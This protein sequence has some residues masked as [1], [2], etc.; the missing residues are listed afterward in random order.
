MMCLSGIGMSRQALTKSW[1]VNSAAKKKSRGPEAKTSDPRTYLP[2]S[3][4]LHTNRNASGMSFTIHSG[5]V[6]IGQK[7]RS[8]AIPYQKTRSGG[9]YTDAV[10]IATAW[11]RA[12]SPRSDTHE[13]TLLVYNIPCAQKIRK[14]NSRYQ[15]LVICL[16][17]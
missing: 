5:S 1:F 9:R 10:S 2:H 8:I 4:E 14:G 3:R 16:P 13:H 17:F 7:N 6:S 15:V 11:N 12:L